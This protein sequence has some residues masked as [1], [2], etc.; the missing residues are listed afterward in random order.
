MLTYVLSDISVAIQFFLIAKSRLRKKF[1]L[2]FILIN[3]QKTD[4]EEFLL[5][6]KI[7][8]YSFYYSNF[9]SYFFVF[10]KVLFLLFK[11]KPNIV[12]CH[13]RQATFIGLFSSYILGVKKRIFTRHHGTENHSAKIRGLYF[14]Y[15]TC[16]LATDIITISECTTNIIKY[17][18]S[19]STNKI[20][21]IFHGFDI[22]LFATVNNKKQSSIRK[23]YNITEK[24][25]VIGS[26]ARFVD[27]K[28]IEYTIESFKKLIKTKPR[29]IL[30]LAHAEGPYKK[31][32][33]DK[34][35][36]ISS[37]NYRIISFEKEISTLYSIF[38]IFVHVP[39][40]K[41]CEAFGQV[42]VEALASKIPSTFTLSGIAPEFIKHKVNAYV[43]N[44]KNSQE[45][46]EGMLFYINN[47]ESKIA[48]AR[49]GQEDVT[50]IFSIEKMIDKLE[51]FYLK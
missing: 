39:I 9:L 10:I 35:H 45:I 27:W 30:I 38:D 24:D 25:F 12:H 28:G 21:K 32:I 6:N 11:L 41:Q 26:V 49:K 46:F 50:K 19:N 44:F 2:N 40:D 42:Y 36:N 14:D 23:K 5:A 31:I 29:S 8:T 18:Y 7:P 48:I 22:S 16:L 34:L 51:K 20:T 4:L 15:I 1:N 47:K 33:L 43:C 37:N 3:K 17:E 13:L